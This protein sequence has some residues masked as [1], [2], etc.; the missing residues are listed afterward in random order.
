MRSLP[1]PL[2]LPGR[3]ARGGTRRT[4]AGRPLLGVPATRTPQARR[5]RR[6]LLTAGLLWSLAVVADAFSTVGDSTGGVMAWLALPVLVYVM[7]AFPD[8]RL[9]ARH[10]RLL[11]AVAAALAL[12]FSV[13]L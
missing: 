9:V 11:C 5:F 6:L 3:A 10:D 2:E 13:L 7:L 8:G 1:L 12:A 4:G